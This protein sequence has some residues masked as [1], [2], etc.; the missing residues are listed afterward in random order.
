LT[1]SGGGADLGRLLRDVK[2]RYSDAFTEPGLGVLQDLRRLIGHTDGFLDL[3]ADPGMDFRVKLMSYG[4]PRM[5]VFEFCRFYAGW[6]GS[7]FMER[8]KH[9]G[10][11]LLEEAIDWWGRQ[12]VLDIMG[13]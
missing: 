7:P 9:E 3:L 4:K 1:H 5:D 6:L 2:R 12:D 10:Y 11:E 8:L 13:R